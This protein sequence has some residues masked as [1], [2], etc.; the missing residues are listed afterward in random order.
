MEEKQG[1][2]YGRKRERGREEGNRTARARAHPPFP[3]QDG[4]LTRVCS[5]RRGA[6][7]ASAT[8]A[9]T[10]HRDVIRHPFSSGNGNSLS[11]SLF[12]VL[13]SSFHFFP[14]LSFFAG[15]FLPHRGDDASAERE[16]RR[17]LIFLLQFLAVLKIARASE[18]AREM[19]YLREREVHLTFSRVSFLEVRER[20]IMLM[21][22]WSLRERCGRTRVSR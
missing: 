15:C 13:H 14:S 9:A 8:A 7:A 11:L 22:I 18:R 21:R 2:R 17:V 3:L 19:V 4:S 20:Y 5:R 6:T 10:S 12:P 1:E 16:D